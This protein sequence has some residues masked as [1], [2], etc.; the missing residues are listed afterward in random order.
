[1]KSESF[2]L[3]LASGSP[4]RAFLLKEC[5]FEF[6]I[7]PTN[8]SEDFDPEME[9]AEIPKMLAATKA[10]AALKTLKQN[11]LVLTSDTVVIFENEILNKPANESEAIDMLTRLSGQTHK[12]ITAVCLA[13]T[14]GSE[15]VEEISWVTFYD[16][17]ED[18]IKN[19]VENF[20]PFDKAGSYGAQECLPDNYNP[21]S[22]HERIFLHRIGK[23]DLILKSKPATH[24]TP[25]MV[26]IKEIAGSYFNVM[27]LPIAQLYDKLKSIL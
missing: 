7:R 15:F 8:A 26:A 11:E 16:L 3:V 25:P 13:N 19:Y 14:F 17:K 1:M 5:G 6:E 23:P 24:T 9:V 2:K 27:G 10:E 12:V 22:G 4:R 18:D 20:R 21:C